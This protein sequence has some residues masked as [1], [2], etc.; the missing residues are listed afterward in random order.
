MKI[1][2]NPLYKIGQKVNGG[3][4]VVIYES[5]FYASIAV[6]R[7]EGKSQDVVREKFLKDN[8]VYAVAFDKPHFR[9]TEQESIEQIADPSKHIKVFV[10]AFPESEINPN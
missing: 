3:Q 6:E 4:I 8:Y 9:C 7:Y 2:Q 5:C 10:M 1:R